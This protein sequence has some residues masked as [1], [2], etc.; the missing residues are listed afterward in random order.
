V[1]IP[2]PIEKHLERIYHAALERANPY[3]MVEK[4][5]EVRGKKLNVAAGGQRLAFDLAR[6]SRIILIGTGKATARMALAAERELGDRI[7]GGLISVKPGCEET[8]RRIRVIEAGHPIPDGNS[9]R[10]GRDIAELCRQGDEKTLF[11]NLISGGGSALLSYPLEWVDR[12]GVQRRLTLEEKRETTRL[13]LLSG[14]TIGEVNTVRKHLSAIKGGRLAELM[15]PAVS[16]NLILSD[17]VGDRLDTIASGLATWDDGTFAQAREIL[18]RYGIAGK[19]SA[20]VLQVIE[21]GERG[22]IPETP[23]RGSTVFQRAH[24]L[25]IGTNTASLLAAEKMAKRLGY[26]TMILSSRIVGEAR[27]VGKI[28]AGIGRE[29]LNRG[30]PLRRPACLIAGGETTVTVRGAGRGGRCQEMALSFIT[31]I[32]GDPSH[33]NGVYFLAVSTDGNDGPTDAAGAYASMEILERGKSRGLD[34]RIFLR[35]NDSYGY[36]E[37]AGGLVKTGLTGTNVG[38]LQIVLVP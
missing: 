37:N 28:Y 26:R 5:L 13:L 30:C 2:Q 17:V 23:K 7:D 36:F 22:T 8:F 27:E 29:I 21:E 33:T 32:S 16:V 20:T 6:F 38:D 12:R 31:D 18:E 1:S 10:A 24:N 4:S 11:L 15:H 19:V 3:L 25:L 34:A 9:V 14:A 35:E